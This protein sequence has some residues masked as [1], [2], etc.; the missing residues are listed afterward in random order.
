MRVCVVRSDVTDVES[1]VGE[2]RRR[3]DL[4]GALPGVLDPP[5][6]SVVTRVVFTER[7]PWKSKSLPSWKVTTVDSSTD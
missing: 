4:G 6:S 1:L 3:I 2:A 5:S 7:S